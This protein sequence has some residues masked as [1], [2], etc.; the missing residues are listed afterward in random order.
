MNAGVMDRASSTLSTE[1]AIAASR[2]EF[3]GNMLRSVMVIGSVA[4][5]SDA[6]RTEQAEAVHRPCGPSAYCSTCGSTTNTCGGANCQ[7]RPYNSF[8]CGSGGNCWSISGGLQLCCDCCCPGAQVTNNNHRRSLC[9]DC[10]STTKYACICQY[11]CC[12]PEG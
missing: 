4:A 7:N 1:L 10:G 12:A 5:F 6:L 3:L 2:R 8:R 9:S 11:S